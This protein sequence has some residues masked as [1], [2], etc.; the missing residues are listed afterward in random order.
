[1]KKLAIIL[2]MLMITSSAFALDTISDSD[3]NDVT[4]QA[5]VSILINSVVIVKT[6]QTSGYGDD[7][8]AQVNW[9]NIVQDNTSTTAIGF[10]GQTPLMIDLIDATTLNSLGFTD[11]TEIG[12]VGVK[13]TLP[14]MIEIQST[15][16]QDTIYLNTV[17]G[18]SAT[19]ELIKRFNGG[20]TTQILCD[21]ASIA[22]AGTG[23][24]NTT[25]IITNH[26]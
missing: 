15:G 6:A 9:V 8:G 17:A 10:H 2:A 24:Q 18:G 14:D 7:D 16:N 22:S 21:A 11:G 25:I 5:G 23:G 12:Q 3:L 26:D 19:G 20:G 1:M 4:G 13:I